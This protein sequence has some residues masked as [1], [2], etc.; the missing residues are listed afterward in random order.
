MKGWFWWDKIFCG[1]ELVALPNPT[2]GTRWLL[3]LHV[4]PVLG[5]VVASRP[6]QGPSGLQTG[7]LQHGTP[8]PRGGEAKEALHWKAHWQGKPVPH[9]ALPQGMAY[10]PRTMHVTQIAERVPTDQVPVLGIW[11]HIALRFPHQQDWDLPNS[12]I[13]CHIISLPQAFSPLTTWI[14]HWWYCHF[15]EA[16]SSPASQ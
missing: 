11:C 3:G 16:Q 10:V 15:T 14:F 12:C 2:L 9:R 8:Q 7:H 1:F 13:L 5:V 6:P 4:G